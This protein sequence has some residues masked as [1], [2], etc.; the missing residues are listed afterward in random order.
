MKYTSLQ[1]RQSDVCYCSMLIGQTAILNLSKTW[2]EIEWSEFVNRTLVLPYDLG[3]FDA[4]VSAHEKEALEYLSGF[5][6]GMWFLRYHWCEHFKIILSVWVD[7]CYIIFFVLGS[8]TIIPTVAEKPKRQLVAA[9]QGLC[10]TYVTN[11]D[12]NVKTL[13]FNTVDYTS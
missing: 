7:G 10:N 9:I 2:S 12:I 1:W 5:V 6:P 3:R 4:M 8:P 11:P 13:V